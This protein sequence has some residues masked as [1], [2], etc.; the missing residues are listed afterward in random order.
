MELRAA[1]RQGQPRAT[2]RGVRES[3]GRSEAANRAPSALRARILIADDSPD[4]LAFLR[5]VL[6]GQ[7][8]VCEAAHGEQVLE[9]A[10][11]GDVR[12]ILLDVIMPGMGGFEAC[13]RLKED[14]ATREIPVLFLTSLDS[15]DE[16]EHGLLLGA[17]DFIHKPVSAPVVLARVRNQLMLWDARRDLEQ[18]SR[19]LERRVA[20]R[21]REILERDR[22]LI[23]SQAATIGAFCALVEAR[24][25]ETGNHIRR[26]QYYVQE[27]AER[28]STHPDFRAQLTPDTI[29]LIVKSAPLHDVGKVAIPDAVL[30]KP[31]KLTPEEWVTMK[32][33]CEIGRNAIL[34]ALEESGDPGGFL[35]YA[36]EIAYSHHEH[37][38]GKGYPQGLRGEAIPL[39]GRLMAVADV[40]DA[41]TTKRVYKNAFTHA[42]AIETMRVER[43][44]HFDPRILDAFIEIV[45]VLQQIAQR[46]AD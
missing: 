27:L 33:H 2:D 12:L 32:T 46:Y 35:G 40:Y 22:Q 23:A 45:D 15:A 43:G 3:R 34:V 7:Y 11:K 37:W 28:L 44:E 31:G 17:A 16:E 19:Q 20:E 24:N 38:N 14:V 25:N 21:T 6:G 29:Q 42:E 18:Y 26:T 13:R 10:R 30:L 9:Q 8:E 1:V 4:N 5:E 41:L 36:A 39:S